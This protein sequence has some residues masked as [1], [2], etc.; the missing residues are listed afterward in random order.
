MKQEKIIINILDNWSKIDESTREMWTDLIE[1]AGFYPYLEKEK[2]KLVFKNTAGEIRKEFHKSDNLGDKYLHEEQKIH[3]DILKSEKNLIVS[4]PTSF[5]KSVLIEEVIASKKYKNIVVIQ[6]TLALLDETRKKLK[7]YKN[8]YKIIVRTS[9]EPSNEK[10]NLFI[11]TAERVWEYHLKLPKIDFFVIDEFYKLSAKRDDERSDV[12]NIA[13]NLLVNKHKSKFYLLGPNIGAISEGFAKKYN[14]E[15]VKTRYSL[16][17]NQVIDRS[18]EEFGERGSK[19]AKKENALFELLLNLKNEQTIIYCSSPARVRYLSKKFCDYLVKQDIEPKSEEL[20]IIEW[21][22][23]NVSDKWGVINCLNY[24]IGIH[25]GALQKHITSSFIH[26]FNDNKLKYLFCTST[27]IEGVNTSAKN[28]VFFDNTKGYKKP[29][30]FFDYSNIKGR[31]GRMMIHYIGRIFNFNKPPDGEQIIVDIPFFEQ[32]PVRDEVLIHIDEKDVRNKRSKQY[33]ELKKIPSE[34][35]ELFKNNGVLIEGQKR[36]LEILK[37]DI[38]DKY[39]LLFWHGFPGYYQLE[40]VLSLAW[41]N[42]IT[43]GET[44][45]PMT[46]PKLITVTHKYGGKENQSIDFLVQNTFQFYKERREECKELKPTVERKLQSMDR[47]DKRRYKKGEE[48]KK[49]N[50]YKKFMPMDDSEL[51]DEAVRDAF[52]I[53][54]HWFHYKVS[55][56][57][58]VMNELQKYVCEKNN[59]EPGNYAYY[60]NQVENDFVRK[61]LS[62]LVEYGVPK[63]AINKLENKISKDLNED[64]VLDEIRNRELIETSELIDYEKEKIREN[65]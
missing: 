22:K 15:F 32:N 46:L 4:A 41:D 16:V 5:G 6:P 59:L 39:D 19:K 64:K 24:G 47:E 27:I 43:E 7:K 50:F 21:I 33:T 17:D 31:S 30:D 38:H 45:R 37:R 57:L 55:K 58:N 63:S 20:S 40:Y 42:L 3:N 54:R 12:L 25:D 2:N 23:N 56:W 14:A 26:Y 18:S 34:E 51:F 60:A 61:N 49:Y 36:I 10:G 35:R 52:Q 13:F 65:L 11:L 29:I 44:T 48:Y 28:V 9:Q 8:D 62:I 53:L 1:A